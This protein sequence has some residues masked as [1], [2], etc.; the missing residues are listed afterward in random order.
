MKKNIPTQKEIFQHIQDWHDANTDSWADGNDCIDFFENGN[1]WDKNVQSKRTELNKETLSIN[2]GH[3]HLKSVQAKGKS[4]ELSLDIFPKNDDLSK[5]LKQLSI[6]KKILNNIVLRKKHKKAFLSSLCKMYSFGQSALFAGICR[7]SNETLNKIPVVKSIDDPS[8][9]FFDV[10]AESPTKNDGR[11]CGICVNMPIKELKS[12]YPNADLSKSS[13]TTRVVDYWYVSKEKCKYIKLEG[14]VYKREEL[15]NDDDIVPSAKSKEYDEQEGTYDV[16][17]HMRIAEACDK[18]LEPPR[19]YP[20]NRL[21]GVY[22][23]GLTYWTKEGF[24]SKPYCHFMKDPQVFHNYLASQI[25]T[26]AKNTTSD[27]YFLSKSRVRT[28][29]ALQSAKN[30]NTKEGVIILD[31]GD[32]SPIQRETPSPIA[33]GMPGVMEQAKKD[34]EDVA[35]LFTEST[36]MINNLSGVAFDKMMGVSNI[37]QNNVIEAH[38]AMVQEIGSI[39][40]DMIPDIYSK[41][42]KI[43][44]ENEHQ[45]IEINKPVKSTKSL[46]NDIKNMKSNFDFN[47]NASVSSAVEKQMVAQE[48][49]QIYNVFPDAIPKTIDLYAKMLDTSYSSELEARMSLLIDPNLEKYT[50]GE[51]SRQEFDE[52]EAQ[53]QEESIQQQSSAQ[54]NTPEFQLA[55]QKLLI[56]KFRAM[57]EQYKTETERMRMWLQNEIDKAGLNIDAHKLMSSNILE[58]EKNDISR[59]QTHAEELKSLLSHE[60]AMLK[61]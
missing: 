57:G 30:I 42:R 51:I 23:Y 48:L 5:N 17:K 34:I 52:L 41:Y 46:I 53:N 11:F 58:S 27:K 61:R 20:G 50:S 59:K 43:E 45:S 8:T 35:G 49:R 44:L 47:I 24:K 32:G 18:P 38:V 60:N 15:I 1:Q 12:I 2:L 31:D 13:E 26:Q 29:S 10:K 37:M 40:R 39:F 6:Y 9:C 4:I 14:G 19:E 33:P 21:P 16:V 28:E 55:Q 25:A 56:E 3:K 7:E 36:A 54:Q 22:G